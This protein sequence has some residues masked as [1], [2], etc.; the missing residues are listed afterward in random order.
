MKRRSFLFSVLA[1]IPL[2]NIYKIWASEVKNA[3]K[4]PRQY[5]DIQDFGDEIPFRCLVLGDWGTGGSLQKDVAL[6]MNTYAEK[7]PI[8]AIISTGDNIYGSGVESVHDK[9]WKTKFE[10]IYTGQFIQ[11]PWYAILGNHDHRGNTE[12]Q[13]EYAKINNAWHMPSNYYSTIFQAGNGTVELFAIDTTPFTKGKQEEQLKWLDT[14]LQD[15]KADWKIVTGHHMMRSYGVY[16]DQQ[17]MLKHIKPLLDK[18][19]VSVYMCGHDHDMQ[20]IN[21][22]DDAFIHVTSGAG[23]GSRD[24]AYGEFSLYAATN[25]GFAALTISSQVLLIHIMDKTGTLQFAH[26]LKK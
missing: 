18:H 26:A 10:N 22:P 8:Q 5:K 12:A 23:G 1:S 19:K 3:P 2:V 4:E 24:T 7:N 21:N 13:I 25:G 20:L 17:F 11:K 9:Q 16:K 15:S 6:G 14:S